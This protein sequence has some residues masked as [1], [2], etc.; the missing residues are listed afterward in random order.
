MVLKCVLLPWLYCPFPVGTDI[1]AFNGALIQFWLH[2][3]FSPLP[4][5]GL[6]PGHHA[7]WVNKRPSTSFRFTSIFRL[8][9]GYFFPLVP[10]QGV[11]VW[12]WV[13]GRWGGEKEKERDTTLFIHIRSLAMKPILND[14]VVPFPPELTHQ[15]FLAVIETTG[16][17]R[18]SRVDRLE[19]KL[20]C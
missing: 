15:T 8:P 7:C 11:Y 6:N 17:N 12:D 10:L 2:L 18:W 9:N 3:V 16:G 4:S 20:A 13:W 14:T 5:W 19:N 1:D